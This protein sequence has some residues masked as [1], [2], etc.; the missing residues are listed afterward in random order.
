[1]GIC[2]EKGA[3]VAR[4][5]RIFPCTAEDFRS[6]VFV[7]EVPHRRHTAVLRPFVERYVSCSGW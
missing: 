7:L 3:N 2:Q 6:S 4:P 1:M 5:P